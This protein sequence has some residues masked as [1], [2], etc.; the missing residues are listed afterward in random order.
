MRRLRRMLAT[1]VIRRIGAVPNHYR[2][3]WTE[4]GMSVWDVEDDRAARA[5]AQGRGAALRHPLLPPPAPAAALALQP[6]R[7]GPR[8]GTRGGRGQGRGDRGSPGRRL[9]RPH[10]LNSTRILKKT[11]LRLAG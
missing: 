10:V 6:V 4:N 5:R 2:L 1:G 11:G 9:P 8:P 3:G 7:H